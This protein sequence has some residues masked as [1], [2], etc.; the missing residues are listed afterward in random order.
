[1]GEA[2]EAAGCRLSV[3]RRVMAGNHHLLRRIEVACCAAPESSRIS[4][5]SR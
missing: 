2:Q 5:W 3:Q 4:T 1:V